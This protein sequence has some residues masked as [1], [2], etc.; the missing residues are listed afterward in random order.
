MK[1]GKQ[2][3]LDPLRGFLEMPGVGMAGGIISWGVT[4]AEPEPVCL[5]RSETTLIAFGLTPPSLILKIHAT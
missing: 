3:H 5:C 1:H 4:G 2:L